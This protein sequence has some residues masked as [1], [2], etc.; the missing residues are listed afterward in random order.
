[1]VNTFGKLDSDLVFVGQN[2]ETLGKMLEGRKQSLNTIAKVLNSLMIQLE[3][4][5]H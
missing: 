4:W 2:G 3:I 5:E 1:M